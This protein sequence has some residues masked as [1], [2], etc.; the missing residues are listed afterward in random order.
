V[1]DALRLAFTDAAELLQESLNEEGAADHKLT[2]I[3]E[4]SIDPQAARA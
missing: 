3:A 2:E 1:C 4:T